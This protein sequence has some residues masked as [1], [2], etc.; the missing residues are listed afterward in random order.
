MSMPRISPAFTEWSKTS[1][2]L[3]VS[4]TDELSGLSDAEFRELVLTHLG[5]IAGFVE[6]MGAQLDFIS[7]H[8]SL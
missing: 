3:Q 4:D 1:R 8:L 7:E 6:A 5:A 2:L